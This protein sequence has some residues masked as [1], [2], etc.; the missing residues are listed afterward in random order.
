VLNDIQALL[1]GGDRAGAVRLGRRDRLDALA[2][3]IFNG[4]IDAT[5]KD[6][7]KSATGDLPGL[8]RS[9]A[10]P[11]LKGLGQVPPSPPDFSRGQ[12][13]GTDAPGSG[14]ASRLLYGFRISIFFALI[15]TFSG[16]IVGTI[17]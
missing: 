13:I 2:D 11:S 14:V 9:G 5:L 3:T 7:K 8:A 10:M 6:P 16:Q 4:S 17:I 1:A 15:L 12:H